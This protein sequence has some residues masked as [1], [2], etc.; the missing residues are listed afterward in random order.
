VHILKPLVLKIPELKKS[1]CSSNTQ[2][3]KKVMTVT[4]TDSVSELGMLLRYT[5]DPAQEPALEDI[6]ERNALLAECDMSTIE[7]AAC[8]GGVNH[9]QVRVLAAQVKKNHLDIIYGRKNRHPVDE[10]GINSLLAAAA[11]WNDRHP[12]YEPVH[13]E[14]AM[15]VAEVIPAPVGEIRQNIAATVKSKAAQSA[16]K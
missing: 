2:R 4:F 11:D 5:L 13:E 9:D 12:E 1:S 10:D 6:N 15:L 8:F 7:H 14:W 3:K 16:H